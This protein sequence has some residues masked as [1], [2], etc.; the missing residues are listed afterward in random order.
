MEGQGNTSINTR[1]T[2]EVEQPDLT[3]FYGLGNTVVAQQVF[4]HTVKG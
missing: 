3:L 2:E 4:P 1:L